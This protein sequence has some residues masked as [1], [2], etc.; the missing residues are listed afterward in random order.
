MEDYK[1]IPES[2]EKDCTTI[3]PVFLQNHELKGQLSELQDGFFRLTSD[4]M[5]LTL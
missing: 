5:E 4:N 2:T 1:K 3:S